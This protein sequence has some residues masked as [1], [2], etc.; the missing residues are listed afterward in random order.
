MTVRA[1]PTACFGAVAGDSVSRY[2]A[3]ELIRRLGCAELRTCDSCVVRA[4]PANEATEVMHAT[5][6][7]QLS[8]HRIGEFWCTDPAQKRVTLRKICPLAVR[9]AGLCASD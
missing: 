7:R 1:G 8:K 9:A 6:P 2:E 5:L 3:D 4:T